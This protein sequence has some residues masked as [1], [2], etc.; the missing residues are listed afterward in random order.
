MFA[1][2][3]INFFLMVLIRPRIYY[4]CLL[5]GFRMDILLIQRIERR[6]LVCVPSD[7]FWYSEWT[8]SSWSKLQKKNMF[9]LIRLPSWWCSLF[10]VHTI[11]ISSSVQNGHLPDP[12]H[13]QKSLNL[14][15]RM[16]RMFSLI[17]IEFLM[18]LI[19]PCTSHP[20]LLL[21]PRIKNGH[22]PVPTHQNKSMLPLI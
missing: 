11:I 18:L 13:Q 2:T 10:L 1:F 16:K 20:C 17:R 15:H 19:V 7:P 5:L 12:K 14:K 22:P 21:L 9:P 6:V 8:S 4:H 3:W